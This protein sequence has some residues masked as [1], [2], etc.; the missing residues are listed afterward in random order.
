MI[1]ADI[2]PSDIALAIDFVLA[3]MLALVFALGRPRSWVRDRLGWV[4]FYY[5]V[6]T[7]ALLFLIVWGIVFG[8]PIDEPFRFTVAAAL[9]VALGW[10]TYAIVSERR[11]GRRERMRA[12]AP[13]PEKEESN[14]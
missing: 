14:S 3:V 13:T 2:T 5:A 4:I 9:A 12:S 6:T 8:Q 7:V 10:K 1:L 11:A